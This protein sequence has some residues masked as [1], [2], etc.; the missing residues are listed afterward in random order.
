MPFSPRIVFITAPNLEEAR[1]LAKLILE[2]RLAA[3]VNL[4]PGVES[5][6]WW[7][8]MIGNASEVLLMVKSSGE[9][10]EQLRE[11]VSLHH[12]YACPEIVAVNPEEV[13]PAYREWWKT[14]LGGK[15]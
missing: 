4:V 11:L 15:D 9:Q 1:G 13:A 7:K 5:H 2:A 14:G 3:C 12:S 8:D 10:F 6:Y